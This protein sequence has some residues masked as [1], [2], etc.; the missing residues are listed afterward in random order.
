[1]SSDSDKKEGCSTV[2][3]KSER[4]LS[5]ILVTTESLN[6]P[7]KVLDMITASYSCAEDP[8]VEANV[9]KVFDIVYEKLR[10]QCADLGGDAVINCQSK[11][12]VSKKKG[13]ELI[14]LDTRGAAVK[15]VNE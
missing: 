2:S 10:I 6:R 9:D 11:L 13:N 5:D 1:M 12:Q 15:Y 8:T 3:E 7:Y 4:S 14:S